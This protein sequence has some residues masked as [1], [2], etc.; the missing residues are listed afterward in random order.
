[1]DYSFR[2]YLDDLDRNWYRDDA[3]LRRLL[4]RH[5]GRHRFDHGGAG[6]SDPPDLER[7]GERVSGP[8]RELAE[9]SARPENRPRLRRR[10]AYGRRVDEVVLPDSTLRALREVEG[11]EGLGALHGDPFDFYARVYLC[12][13]NGEA[14]VAC[15]MA[16]TDGLVRV[17]E[18]LGDRPEHERAVERVRGSD[19]DRVWH[20]AQFV[21][22]P[23]GGSDVPANRTRAERA[24]G[25]WRISG[26]K[27]FCSNVNADYFLVT[28]RPEGAPE[29]GRGVGLFLV[30]ARREGEELRN[31]HTIER[32]KE[33]L[34]TRELA[35]AEV[36][37]D[38]ALGWPVGPLERGL[39]NLV[40]HVLVPSRFA[41]VISAAAFLR[42]AERIVDAY[43]EFRTAFGHPIADF[44]LVA[45]TL[46]EIRE[47]R[48]QSLAAVFR[49]LELWERAREAREEA[50]E[51]ADGG[52]GSTGREAPGTGPE[53]R[54]GRAGLRRTSS[55]AAADFRVLLS[56]CKPVLTR[57]STRLLHEAM[58][59]LGGQGVEEEFSPLPRLHRDAVIMETWEG[60]HAVLYT[61]AMNDLDRLDFDADAFVGR[62]AASGTAGDMAGDLAGLLDR[63]DDPDTTVPFARWARRMVRSFGRRELEEADPA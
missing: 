10:D 8:L 28:A 55:T 58:M 3:L 48:A 15:S 31:G 34:G 17:L 47:A 19:R 62:H 59:L 29:G 36:T 53:G 27:W 49:L 13:Q 54:R 21:T 40:R 30:P 33:K 57:R 46:D 60:P 23:Q 7:W 16:C 43:T 25:G 6:A 12:Q 14:G 45:E 5:R 9:V 50:E 26:E 56:L 35:T 32:L 44:P 1:M 63:A 38:G 39:P 4:E 41:C 51:T 61:Q 20:G 18:A 37:F 22:E 11:A 42:R 2:P 52:E 24:D